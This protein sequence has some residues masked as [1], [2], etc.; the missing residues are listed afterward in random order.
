[1]TLLSGFVALFVTGAIGTYVYGRLPAL[2]GYALGVVLFAFSLCGLWGLTQAFVPKKRWSTLQLMG[3]GALFAHIPF[4]VL[5]AKAV[6]RLG[7]PGPGSFLVG[8]AL[9]YCLAVTWMVTRPR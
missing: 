8:G 2:E 6:Q 7:G 1:M 5:G 3:L 4:F 9:V